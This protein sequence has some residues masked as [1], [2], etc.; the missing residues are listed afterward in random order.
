MPPVEVAAAIAPVVQRHAADRAG[1]VRRRPPPAPGEPLGTDA[2]Q[3]LLAGE[4]RRAVAGQHH[5]RRLF[6]H[7]AGGVDRR[8]EALQGGHRPDA[9]VGPSMIAASSSKR[10]AVLGEAPRPAT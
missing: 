3:A 6:H 2:L 5:V 7:R 1:G 10:P 4:R 9:A 8:G